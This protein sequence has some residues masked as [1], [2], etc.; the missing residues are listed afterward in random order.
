MARRFAQ[1]HE[2]HLVLKGARTLV[3]RPDGSVSI[4]PTGNPGMASGGMG[5]VLTG[6]IGGLL[7]QGMPMG[8]ALDLGVYLHGLAGDQVAAEKGTVG[9]AAGDL[10][11]LL[12]GIIREL[13]EKTD[14]GKQA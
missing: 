14:L 2:V 4:N 9:M 5:D 7:A 3:A 11:C 13:S 12:P 6:M 8:D 1:E 10:L